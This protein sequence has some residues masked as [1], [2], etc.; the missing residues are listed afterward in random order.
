MTS[1]RATREQKLRYAFKVYDVDGDGKI[2]VEDLAD[3]LLTLTESK[4]DEV[5]MKEVIENVFREADGDGDGFIMF[6]D[7]SKIVLNTD[8]EGKLTMEF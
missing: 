4:M 1:L 5:T 8:I 3:T 6:E 2:S 7:F